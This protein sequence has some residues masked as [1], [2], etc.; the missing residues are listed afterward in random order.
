MT[1]AQQQSSGVRSDPGS[2]INP[3]RSVLPIDGKSFIVGKYDEYGHRKMAGKGA[4]SSEVSQISK[5]MNQ[6]MKT[7]GGEIMKGFIMTSDGPVKES[8]FTP[9]VKPKSKQTALKVKDKNVKKAKINEEPTQAEYIQEVK[10]S[11]NS[12][13]YEQVLP[14]QPANRETFPVVFNIESGR[15]KS[16]A[17]SILEDELGLII[18]YKDLDSIS[19]IPKK[20][21]KLSLSLPNRTLSVMY[22]GMQIQWYNTNQ[23]LLIFV[24]MEKE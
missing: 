1:P 2:E 3:N 9:V 20:G 11:I 6:S 12:E 10:N 23:Q 8:Q 21:G 5:L 22:L 14:P 13:E 24:K 4:D 7:R 16:Q 19:Y 18:V 17:D 15:I